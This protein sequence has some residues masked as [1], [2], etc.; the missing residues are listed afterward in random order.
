MADAVYDTATAKIEGGPFLFRASAQ[1]L[2]FPGWLAVT[3]RDD[4]VATRLPTLTVDEEVAPEEITPEQHFTKPPP[5]YNDASLVQALEENGIGRPSTYAPTVA[6]IIDRRYVE[7]ISRAFHP[8]ELGK[9]VNAL[10]VASFP[11]IF[12]VTFTAQI[13]AELDAVE[14]GEAE[15]AEVLGDFYRPF[16]ADLDQAAEVMDRVRDEASERTDIKCPKCGGVM[17]VKWGRFGK[18]LRCEKYPDCSGTMNFERDE[19]GRIVPVRPEDT[20]ETCDKCGGPMVVKRGRYGEFL[21]CDNYPDCKNTK[22][23]LRKVD[24][25]C[26]K[27][28]GQIVQ[29]KGKRGRPFYG[30]DKYP[31]CDFTANAVP[32]NEECPQCG[33]N[34][35]LRGRKYNRCPNKDC[36]YKTEQG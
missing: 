19:E 3:P 35:L 25:R 4:D 30:C 27:C 20:G 32:V 8:T 1:A 17:E 36:G 23:I 12:D 11:D 9:L 13:E 16:A 29:R 14:E 21:A 28:G 24:A 26:P 5:R 31:D 7:R 10:L 22:P 15:W 2:R 34:Y 33:S 18:Y 6:T